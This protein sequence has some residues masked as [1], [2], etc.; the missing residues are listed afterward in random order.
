MIMFNDLKMNKLHTI[1]F[2]AAALI[3]PI[4]STVFASEIFERL[5]LDN[6]VEVHLFGPDEILDNLTS[7]DGE[8]RLVMS[9]P[10]GDTYIFLEDTSNPAIVN[11]GDGRFHPMNIEMVVGA[12][13]EIDLRGK[14][15]DLNVEVYVLPYP[16]QFILGSSARENRIFLSPGVYEVNRYVTAFTVTH[17]FGHVFQYE[18]IPDS[19]EDGWYR[20]LNLRGIYGD[21]RY[22]SSSSHMN[23]PK[24]IFAEDFR[25]LFGG[26]DARYSGSIENPD[27]ALPDQVP[28]LESF[29]VSLAGR[30]VASATGPPGAGVMLSASNY[31]NPFNP[32]TTIRVSFSDSGS[33]E[34]RLV[35]LRI[36]GI[37][38]SLVRRLYEGIAAGNELK[39]TWDGKNDNGVDVAS[40]T[41][42]YRF[43]M[44]SD[45]AAGKML[46][47]R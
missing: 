13:D 5:T 44:V 23:R 2:L 17:E 3:V 37:D 42:F 8:G 10:G 35:D 25:Y 4:S 40:G 18:Y 38:G 1:L 26:E 16:R 22:T 7:R 41:Y 6:G 14:S 19:D 20:Y 46:L 24:E 21:E 34:S 12:L 15:I 31:P 43:R 45:V 30:D 36:Y 27:I 9:L 47:I 28:G 39:V 33:R 11:K 29:M 32:A